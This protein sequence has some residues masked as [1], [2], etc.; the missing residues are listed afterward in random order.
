MTA[1]IFTLQCY[2]IA[3]C[4]FIVYVHPSVSLPVCLS[5]QILYVGGL[6]QVLA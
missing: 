2:A 4:A 5:C 1:T 6:C 3:V